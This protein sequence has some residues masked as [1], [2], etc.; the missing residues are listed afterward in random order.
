[1]ARR[2][3]KAMKKVEELKNYGKPMSDIMSGSEYKK[4][5][6]KITWVIIG[7]L[8]REL[9][10]IGLIKLTLKLRKETNRGKARDWSSLNERGMTNQKFLNGLISQTAAGKALSDIVG[11]DKASDLFRRVFDQTSD[12]L[13]TMWP[14]FEDFKACEDIVEAFRQYAKALIAAEVQAG[15]HEM[16]IV[17]DSPK[18]MAINVKY[19]TW[20]EVAKKFGDPYLCYLTSCA[21]DEVLFPKLIAAG[22]GRFTRTGTLATGAPVCDFRFELVSKTD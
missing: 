6:N 7:E 9:G 21:G 14:S 3:E 19:C 2:E 11:K 8:R 12:I 1:M 13:A 22:G 10:L 16:E 15:I 4:I 17:E 20:C 18:A 5:N